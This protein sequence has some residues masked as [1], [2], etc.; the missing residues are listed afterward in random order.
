MQLATISDPG[1]TS[2]YTGYAILNNA[3]LSPLL[4]AALG[5]VGRLLISIHKSYH[6]VFLPNILRVVQLVILVSLIFGIVGGIDARSVYTSDLETDPGARDVRGTLTKAGTA[7]FIVSCDATVAST[8]IISFLVPRA[9]PGEKRLFFAVAIAPP[10]L[11]VR[12]IYSCTSTFTTNLHFNLLEGDTTTLLFMA[13][14][15]E[16]CV[17]TLFFFGGTGLKLRKAVREQ[18]RT[19]ATGEIGG[20]ASPEPLQKK[21]GA[22]SQALNFSKYTS[23][24]WE[25]H[26]FLVKWWERGSGD[27]VAGDGE[28]MVKQWR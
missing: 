25:V 19:L 12:L 24:H 13:F 8:T 9:E 5:F 18:R 11:F 10:F 17:M 3:G 1:N 7:L 28:V 23:G 2:L 21:T 14:V 22:G 26:S 15:M 16:L 27:A 20:S 6:A 4:F